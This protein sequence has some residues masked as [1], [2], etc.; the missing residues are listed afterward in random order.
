LVTNGLGG[1]ACG[2]VAGANTRRY[3]AFLMASLAPPVARTLMVAKVDVSV[4]YLGTQTELGANE[5]TDGTIAPQGFK[6]L[7]SFMVLDGIPTWIYAVDDALLVQQIF[8]PARANTAYLR[9]ELL[10]ASAPLRIDLRPFVAYR[11]YH[12]QSRGASDLKTES[13]ER[14][15]RVSCGG[16]PPF[17][18]LVNRGAFHPAPTMYWNFMHREEAARGLD[19]AEDL[20]NPG[21]FS[22]D[23]A[24]GAP[25]FLIASAE[26][27]QPLAGELVLAA[28]HA[29]HQE[30][31]APLPPNAPAWIRE[32]A[33]AADQFI[34]RRGASKANGA[35]NEAANISIVAG[36]PWFADWGRDT[37]ISLPGLATALKR[38]DIA[39]GV[40]R[41]Y[42]RFV[43]G[44]MIPNRFPDG[45][46]KP[47]YNTADATLWM[48]HAIDD[49]L[50][51]RPDPA[52]Q[53]ELYPILLN[54][55]RAHQAGTRFGIRVDPADGLLHSGEPG[56]QLTWMDAKQGDTAFTP[57]I[58]KAVEVNALWLNALDVMVRLAA[59]VG[60]SSEQSL[61]QALLTRAADGFGRFWN[62]QR[63]CL[64]DVLDA[65]GAHN[66]A[67][68]RPNQILAVSLP[69]CTL[70]RAQMRAVVDTCARELVTSY[71]LRS[72]ARGEPGYIGEYAGSSFQRDSAYHMGTVWSWL[73][74]PFARAH[75]RVYGDARLA[76]SFLNPIAQHVNAAC[77]GNVSEVFDAEAPHAA[78]GCFAQAWGVAEILRAWLYLDRNVSH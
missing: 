8:M 75:F 26:P 42:A 9:L 63:S 13:G 27:A 40:L 18:L 61:C 38:Y 1:Y 6:H 35:A 59:R 55:I 36:Y 10:R 15:C 71:G 19:A 45:G 16:A 73:L 3:H 28:L 11:D 43:D 47:E 31:T 4:E 56:T 23:L 74:G 53:A 66:D 12:S 65:P 67:S 20:L 2:T 34:V 50:A 68:I 14:E 62:E 22:A 69:Y 52:L 78:R 32:L 41:T 24:R 64:F 46:E 25:V 70:S 21:L 44:G 30:L 37:M 7:Q 33:L 57:R 76:N 72:L 48:F 39:A 49:Y 29:R 54:V 17:R 58:G 60:A 5:F 51:A 77:L